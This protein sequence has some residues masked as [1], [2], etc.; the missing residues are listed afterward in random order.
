[1][2]LSKLLTYIFCHEVLI[3]YTFPQISFKLGLRGKW[4]VSP[5]LSPRWLM[6][7]LITGFPFFSP[8]L[9]DRLDRKSLQDSSETV[10]RKP[11]CPFFRSIPG[12]SC[13]GPSLWL[14]SLWHLKL[15]QSLRAPNSMPQGHTLHTSA[16]L[17][18]KMGEAGDGESL[19]ST[20]RLVY[21]RD[22]APAILTHLFLW[23]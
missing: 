8:Q 21:S 17:S 9:S 6:I 3:P 11:P 1:M 10:N 14:G 12:T 22:Q 19:T 23:S 5:W 7:D 20:R 15:C 13:H 2:E 18:I 4:P 16:T